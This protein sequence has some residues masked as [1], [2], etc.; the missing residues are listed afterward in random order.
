M[1]SK[2]SKEWFQEDEEKSWT[3]LYSTMAQTQNFHCYTGRIAMQSS[4]KL[5]GHTAE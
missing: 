2:Q 5:T 1:E 3:K 4:Q